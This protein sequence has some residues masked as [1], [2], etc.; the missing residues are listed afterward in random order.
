LDAVDGVIEVA[1]RAHN[2]AL[3]AEAH[4]L[5]LAAAMLGGRT[6]L[7]LGVSS[8]LDEV[9]AGPQGQASFRAFSGGMDIM[10]FLVREVLADLRAS[11]KHVEPPDAPA[12]QA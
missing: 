6:D 10:A 8:L 11:V 2:R 9:G 12:G 1:R 3:L 5:R 7:L 4:N